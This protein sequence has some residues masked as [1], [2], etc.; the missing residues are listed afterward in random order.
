MQRAIRTAKQSL[1]GY[2]VM[3][4]AT[5]TNMKLRNMDHNKTP[6]LELSVINYQGLIKLDLMK[7][8]FMSAV[9]KLVLLTD[10][11]REK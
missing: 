9:D 3:Q 10:D 6:A 1:G 2:K 7:L 11:G 4:Q 8:H 5:L